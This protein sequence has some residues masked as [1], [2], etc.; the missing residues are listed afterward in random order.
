M[1]FYIFAHV[2]VAVLVDVYL[3]RI[4]SGSLNVVDHVP[5]VESCRSHLAGL[6]L[7]KVRRRCGPLVEKSIDIAVVRGV[8]DIVHSHDVLFSDLRVP[9]FIV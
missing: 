2:L 8:L 9:S 7:H 1:V 5:P 4:K 3:A 6:R